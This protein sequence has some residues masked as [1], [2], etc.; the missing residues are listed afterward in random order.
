MI[1]EIDRSNYEIWLIDWLDGNL[2]DIE[3]TQ[4]QLFLCN[5]PDIKEEYDELTMFRL[6]STGESF[7]Q[8]N[9]LK[10]TT[11]LLPE[12]QLEY[13]C[14]ASL[15]N[16]LS[17][18]Q[19][20]ELKEIIE[21]DPFKKKTFDLIR[22]TKLSTSE[23]TFKHKKRLFRRTFAQDFIRISVIGL[24]AAAITA[25]LIIIY[26]LNP[27]PLPGKTENITQNTVPVIKLKEPLMNKVPEKMQQKD[28]KILVKKT[29]MNL[30]AMSGR[31]PFPA[32]E[33]NIAVYD[34]PDSILRRS[35]PHFSSIAKVPVSFAPELK[36]EVLPNDLIIL[37]QTI[38]APPFDDG[39][40]K[41]SRFIA[42]TFRE[43]ILK[44]KTAKDSPLKGYEIAEA[45]VT[46][47]NRLLGWEM[48]LD[49]KKDEKGELKSIYFSS[50]I[51]KFNAPVKKSEPLQ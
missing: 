43:K 1:M 35:D 21:N 10:K 31:K 11:A 34:Q 7:H 50:K 36:A 8:K 27:E 17:S 26:V 6:S 46:G 25:I 41:I 32:K 22:K 14:V 30:L 33:V 44:E 51:L 15:E 5:N 16:D 28:K 29:N 24:S 20:A 39:R 9:N 40:S 23:D 47:L 12:S 2:D 18:E 4:L 19:E 49:E 45:G 13:L 48:A 38:V 37:N 42:K 3:V